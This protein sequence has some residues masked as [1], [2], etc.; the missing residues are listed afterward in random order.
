MDLNNFYSKVIEVA[1]IQFMDLEDFCREVLKAR[2]Y[3]YPPQPSYE[4]SWLRRGMYI[5]R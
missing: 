4:L 2:L 1:P 5:C 3:L